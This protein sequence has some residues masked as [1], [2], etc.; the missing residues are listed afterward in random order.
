MPVQGHSYPSSSLLAV[1]RRNVDARPLMLFILVSLAANSPLITHYQL[2]FDDYTQFDKTL[3]QWFETRGI[4]R[5]LGTLFPSWLVSLDI[6]G[7]AVVL[8]HAIGGYLFFLVARHGLGSVS[9][10]LF[11]TVIAIAFPWGYQALL[12]ASA[13]SFAFASCLLWAILYVLVVF[14][15]DQL[16]GYLLAAGVVCTSFICLLFNEAAFFPLCFAGIIVWARPLVFLRD[17]KSALVVSLAPLA[18]AG[19]WATA[20][21]LTKPVVPIKAVTQIH[22][23][24]AL[25]ALLYQ[26]HNLGIFSVWTNEQLRK[27]VASTITGADAVLTAL[28]IGAVLFMLRSMLRADHT[29]REL[30]FHSDERRIRPVAF[31]MWM[32]LLSVGAGCIY[33]LAGGYSLDA[34]KRYLIV[35]LIMLTAAAAAWLIW[36]PKRARAF[37]PRGSSIAMSGTCILGCLTSLMMMSL[38]KYELTRL[39]LLADLITEN[40]VSGDLQVDW[41][42]DIASVWPQS[43]YSWGLDRGM[44]LNDALHARGHP[45]ISLTPKSSQRVSWSSEEQRW[46]IIIQPL[47]CGR[48]KYDVFRGT[49]EQRARLKSTPPFSG[50]RRS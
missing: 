50:S 43:E 46:Y 13:A 17:W 10:A 34:R 28:A 11:L 33:A 44:A 42:P 18:G 19:L 47:A 48:G 27:H 49:V 25:S 32:L 35:P 37:W 6:Y 36:G 45:S 12:W 2:Y 38:W 22:L 30:L 40:K 31:L 26:Y 21:E 24:S 4:W 39:N 15:A 41:N 20:Y 1:A 29:G 5:I 9:H 16:R 23:P 14:R 3:A 8:L 7:V